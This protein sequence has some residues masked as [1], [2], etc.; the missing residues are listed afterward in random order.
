MKLSLRDLLWLA[1][2]SATL[3][4]WAVAPRVAAAKKELW[5]WKAA[6]RREPEPDP[7]G[8][9]RRQR[10]ASFTDEQL[11]AFVSEQQ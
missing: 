7:A 1:L 2:L 11:I 5:F 6:E 8:D 10:L 3:A 4:G 9:A